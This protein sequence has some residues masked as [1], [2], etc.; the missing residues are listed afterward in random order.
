MHGFPDIPT[1]A[2]SFLEHLADRG[3]HVI[4]PW[5]PGYAPSP[6]T[7]SMARE[8]VC[9]DLFELIDTWSPDAPIDIVGHDWGA[10][11]TYALCAT[12]PE[13]IRRAVTMSVPHPRTFLRQLRTPAQLL[14]S[15]YM[16]LFQLPGA[17]HLVAARDFALVDRLWRDWSPG[18]RLP[19]DERRALKACLAESMPAPI[20]YYRSTARDSQGVRLFEKP[21][22]TPLLYLH[23]ANDGCIH[24]PAVDD[25][26][27][28]AGEY[29]HEV[30]AGRG[31]FLHVEDPAH[32]AARV[33]EW[34]A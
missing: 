16:V 30:I 9:G 13:R 22:T 12:A 33:A 23:G 14:M 1:T 34:L 3:F 2:R 11:M 7:G 32:I 4:A 19:D 31:H 28:F 17:G 21:L 20:R 24:P 25:S 27:R 26:R 6:T 5:M 15:W 8:R 18:F 29:R 10:V